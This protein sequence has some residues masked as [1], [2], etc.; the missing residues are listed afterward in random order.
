MSS[1]TVRSQQSSPTK[2]KDKE[3]SCSDYDSYCCKISRHIPC[4]IHHTI[5]NIMTFSFAIARIYRP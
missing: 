3:S 1:G 4:T 2:P 5:E